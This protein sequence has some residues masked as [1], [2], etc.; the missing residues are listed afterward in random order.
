MENR[1]VH[2]VKRKTGRKNYSSQNE[3]N[4]S[5]SETKN[6][7]SPFKIN[8][9][10][11]NTSS[12]KL[13]PSSEHTSD[14]NQLLINSCLEMF[15]KSF[16][17]IN[18]DDLSIAFFSLEHLRTE[19][20]ENQP[21]QGVLECQIIFFA[22]C[23]IGASIQGNITL[24]HS[25]ANKTEA[26]LASATLSKSSYAFRAHLLVSLMYNCV[27]KSQ[28]A[29]EH[30]WKSE[31][32]VGTAS[33][34]GVIKAYKLLILPVEQLINS[35]ENFSE[36]ELEHFSLDSRL[37]CESYLPLFKHVVLQDELWC[38]AVNCYSNFILAEDYIKTQAQFSPR[39]WCRL[40]PWL[41]FLEITQIALLENGVKRAM[42]FV[43]FLFQNQQCMSYLEGGQA[44]TQGILE[45]MAQIFHEIKDAEFYYIAYSLL[46]VIGADV[47]S[48][49]S[50][51][52]PWTGV[53]TSLIAVCLRKK[54]E[55]AFKNRI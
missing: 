15:G 12:D 20:Q 32:L 41:I 28:A 36:Y 8:N 21:V 55:I 54:I 22:C 30:M 2:T 39:N 42:E 40:Q 1:C 16:P 46:V 44:S 9:N 10:D 45:C 48:F 6:I 27:K 5:L 23:S 50:L 26:A 4:P 18:M 38:H 29:L 31:N 35:L 3:E 43:E 34:N 52:S 33:E 25:F 53:T 24:A 11:L 14:I 37:W 51:A 49:P 13:F 19:I 7:Y 17:L 47:L